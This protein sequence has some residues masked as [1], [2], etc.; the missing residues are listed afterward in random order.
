MLVMRHPAAFEKPRALARRIL[1]E[2]PC[3]VCLVPGNAPPRVERILAGI[4]TDD[5]GRNVLSQ[6]A[7]LYHAAQA[8]ELL[9]V[10]SCFYEIFDG[11][12]VMYERFC[13]ERTLELYRFMAG[14]RLPGVSCTPVLAEGAAPQRVLA[15]EASGRS[16]DLVVVGRQLGTPARIS[17]ELLKVCQLPLV[18]VL[19]PH[20]GDGMR[21]RLRRFFSNPE[22][23]FG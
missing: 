15:R 5:S 11:D 18:Q 19:L 2:S 9:A 7:S 10:H 12:Q 14:M 23:K 21:G 6:A 17:T 13:S 1:H 16:A 20:P 4:R 8:E 3:S 22:P